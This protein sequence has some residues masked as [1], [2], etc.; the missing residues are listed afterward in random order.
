MWG[1]RGIALADFGALDVIYG[2]PQ[3]IIDTKVT[4][5]GVHISSFT[6]S[7][8]PPVPAAYAPIKLQVYRNAT[9]ASDTFTAD[10]RLL[11][12]TIIKT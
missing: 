7:I 10:A 1:A 3:N 12:V 9:N 2:P 5:S 11:G 4:S 8:T 6:S